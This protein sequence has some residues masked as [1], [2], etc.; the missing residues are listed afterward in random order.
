MICVSMDPGSCRNARFRDREQITGGDEDHPRAGIWAH[1]LA[2]RSDKLDSS[3]LSGPGPRLKLV[4][5]RENTCH[6][7]DAT[8]YIWPQVRN[9][10]GEE[11]P[12]LTA[13]PQA[14]RMQT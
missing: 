7:N 1:A 13:I 4:I 5:L 14:A 8:L 6:L 2:A 12:Q 10:S 9:M 3:D 11:F